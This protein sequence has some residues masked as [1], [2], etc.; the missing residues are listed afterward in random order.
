[1]RLRCDVLIIGG[2]MAG[3]R[4]AIEAHDHGADVL[5]VS[6]RAPGAGGASFFPNSLPWGIMTAGD[7]LD[8]EHVFFTETVNASCG[9]I[10]EKLT[11]ILARN[12]NARF[13]DLLQ[14]GVPFRRLADTNRVPCFGDKP[15]GAQLCDMRSLRSSML[16]QLEKRSIRL[17]KDV[18][19]LSLNV[20]NR[21]CFGAIATDE[22]GETLYIDAKAAVLATGGA[23][24]LWQYNVVTPDVAGDGY[25]MA[26]LAGARLVNMEFVQ[27]IPATLN[28]PAPLNFHTLSLK[29]VADVKNEEGESIL[30]KYLP[31]NIAVEQCLHARSTHG[32]FSNEDESR[33]F[34][35][36]ISKEANNAQVGA[37]IQYGS[38]YEAEGNYTLWKAFLQER[39]IDAA[40]RGLQ[41]YPHCQ[42]FN[43]G[44][45]I[46]EHCETGIS[47][48]FACGECAG[49]VH[50]ANRM[51][52]NAILAT[53]VFGKIA[54]E[55]AAQHAKLACM[56]SP[57]QTDAK[58]VLK[59]C[60]DNDQSS[61]YTPDEVIVVIKQTLSKNAMV[62]RTESGLSDAMGTI[63]LMEKNYN[64]YQQITEGVSPGKSV[65]AY[66]AL[67]SAHAILLAMAQR[68]ESRGPH[69]RED[70]PRK[71]ARCDTM[72]VVG[73]ENLI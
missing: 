14:Y 53:Q 8:S 59:R 40:K 7:G 15:R 16:S 12:S 31:S 6:K 21:C 44:I 20:M 10:D 29:A 18:T 39:G 24:S 2:G 67:I 62:V 9:C 34:D 17:L 54:G 61:L 64:P 48:L 33:Y 38:E 36:A 41:I 35:I 50:G 58:Q 63:R 71:D 32:P 66:H 55:Q 43:G 1:M 56:A 60:F 45:R 27:F 37:E 11:E 28:T 52:G 5:L 42:G 46:D 23:E 51:G 65:G 68:R 3:I 73:Y 47:G 22:N 30:P 4:A 19:I 25:A 26:L 49:G 13:A 72:R 57:I 69:Y 70:C